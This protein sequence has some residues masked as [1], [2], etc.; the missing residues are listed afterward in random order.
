MYQQRLSGRIDWRAN[1]VNAQNINKPGSCTP[2]TAY[3]SEYHRS[4]Q[5][6]RRTNLSVM[7]SVRP[8]NNKRQLRGTARGW[9]AN[10]ILF[11]FFFRLAECRFLALWKT[12]Q[13]PQSL[14][15]LSVVSHAWLT[16]HPALRSVT[17]QPIQPT[18]VALRAANDSS[19]N[20]LGFVVFS[21]TLGT[22]T[23]DVEAL[24]VPSL[25]PDSTP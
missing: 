6:P 25:G 17:I 1:V 12:I 5:R 18:T 14:L 4:T 11:V 3:V 16:S 15:I 20:V 9:D 22:I 10:P 7:G 2:V 21:L 23:H 8:D 24:V 19:L 13:C